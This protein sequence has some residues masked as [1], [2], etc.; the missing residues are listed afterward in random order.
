MF[1]RSSSPAG[2]VWICYACVLNGQQA[3]ENRRFL[4][5]QLTADPLE[6]KPGTS[7]AEIFGAIG[8]LA[9]GRMNW[10][11]EGKALNIGDRKFHIDDCTKD[12][13]KITDA[14]DK[15]VYLFIAQQSK[16]YTPF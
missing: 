14:R 12:F 4:S 10:S 3:L 8:S 11:L 2:P 9:N 16:S 1:G 7:A 15:T 6:D 5:L 13:L